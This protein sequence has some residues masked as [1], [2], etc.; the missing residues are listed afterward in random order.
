MAMILLSALFGE[1]KMK[2]KKVKQKVQGKPYGKELVLNT[3]L[4][5]DVLLS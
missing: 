4:Q 3:H 2:L 1:K 5:T